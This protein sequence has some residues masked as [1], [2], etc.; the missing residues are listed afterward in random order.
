MVIEFLNKETIPMPYKYDG[1]QDTG[2]ELSISISKKGYLKQSLI[3][4]SSLL[5]ACRETVFSDLGFT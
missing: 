2:A 3:A 4:L 5:F 1:K